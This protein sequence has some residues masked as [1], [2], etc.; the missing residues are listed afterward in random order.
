MIRMAIARLRVIRIG[1]TATAPTR[2][3]AP[4]RRAIHCTKGDSRGRTKLVRINSRVGLAL[5]VPASHIRVVRLA[6]HCK[7]A[8]LPAIAGHAAII[9]IDAAARA[10]HAD[11]HAAFHA[12]TSL[13][14]LRAK[15]R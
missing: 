5:A 8:I 1:H 14:S 15:E 7:M 4:V 6:I 3:R 10:R 11:R 12:A 13:A 2:R 9:R